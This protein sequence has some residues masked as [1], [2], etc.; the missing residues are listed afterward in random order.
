M[1]KQ[2]SEQVKAFWYRK[3]DHE[4]LM[5]SLRYPD[6]KTRPRKSSEIKRRTK[7]ITEVRVATPI[8]SLPTSAPQ[9]Q[10]SNKIDTLWSLQSIQQNDMEDFMTNINA[11]TN[12]SQFGFD[13]EFDL[14]ETEF[15]HI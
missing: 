5:H 7:K 10:S 2:E 6:Y 8:V 4:K 15:T 3:A 11:G 13:T 14:F 1:W 12:K 9:N